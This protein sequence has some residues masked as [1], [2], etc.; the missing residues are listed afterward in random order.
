MKQI[1][2]KENFK[3]KKK[4]V[5]P[6]RNKDGNKPSGEITTGPLGKA[7]PSY[8]NKIYQIIVTL[9]RKYQS[10]FSFDSSTSL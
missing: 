4:C 2:H 10:T 9:K 3:K 8:K 5:S 1:L 7:L 6:S